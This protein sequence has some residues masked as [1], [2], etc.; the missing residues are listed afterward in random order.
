MNNPRNLRKKENLEQS[1]QEQ[2]VGVRNKK[3]NVVVE[4]KKIK[5]KIEQLKSQGEIYQNRFA[6]LDTQQ[7]EIENQL[8]VLST[9]QFLGES[10]TILPKSDNF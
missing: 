8:S 9:M 4:A 6:E 1:L 2:L 10:S 7:K 5:L 3:S